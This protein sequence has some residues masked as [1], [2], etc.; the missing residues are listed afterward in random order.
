LGWN[1][2]SQLS[3]RHEL[4]VLSHPDNRGGVERALGKKPNPALH[5][6]YLTLPGALEL[7][8]KHHKGGIQ[9]YSYSWQ[10]AAY[11]AAR[12]LHREFHFDVFHHMTYANDWMAS[13]IGACLRIPFVRGPGGG[14]DRTPRAFLKEYCFGDRLWER[15]RSLGQWLLRQDPFFRIGQH[16]ARAI[17]VCNREALKRVPQKHRSKA[18]VFPVIGV[19]SSD[20]VATVRVDRPGKTFRVV[21]AGKLLYWKG[22]GLVIKAFK[23]FLD[24]HT[25]PGVEQKP[26][27]II[28]GDGPEFPR[29]RALARRLGLEGDVRFDGWLP[30]DEVLARM[31]SCGVFLYASL[32]DG[33][34]AVVVEA[35]AAGLPV[36]CL[37]LGGPGMHVTEECGIKV[38]AECPEQAVRDLAAALARLYQERELRHRMAKNARERAER[39]YHWDRL[40]ERML[41]IYEHALGREL[42]T[43]PPAPTSEVSHVPF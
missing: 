33:G 9:I 17:L 19:S 38:E 4:W 5:F 15:F 12:R 6:H 2:I 40:G 28:V 35:L 29:L 18:T 42:R 32:R 43:T 1:L 21:S 20:L 16:R 36:V 34:G 14:A 11:F 3:R 39:D 13:F 10:M 25:T 22:F 30:H 41:E 31:R 23:A 7:L 24:T 26:E 37:D 8:S 27:L